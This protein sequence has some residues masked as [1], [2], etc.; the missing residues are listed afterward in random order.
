MAL[1]AISGICGA[2]EVEGEMSE[3]TRLGLGVEGSS[4]SVVGSSST[5]SRPASCGSSSSASGSNSED[6]S[7]VVTVSYTQQLKEVVGS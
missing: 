2:D 4:A 6:I 1:V 5:V 3:T 7:S